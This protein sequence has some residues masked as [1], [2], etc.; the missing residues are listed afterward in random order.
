MR[1]TLMTIGLFALAGTAIGASAVVGQAGDPDHE[2][3]DQGR[4]GDRESERYC[5][6]REFTLPA[7]G[8][9]ISVDGGANGGIE[10]EGW[11][12][13][14]IRLTVK[15]QGWTR[16]GDPAEIVSDVEIQTDRG[17]RAEGPRMGRREGWS[18]SYRMM[19]PA[20]SDLSLETVNGGISVAE[21][22]G[23][24]GFRAVNGGIN[25]TGVGGTVSGRTTN[26]GISV[27]LSGSQWD[28]SGLDVETTNGGVTL[29]VPDDFRADLETGT[30]NGGLEIDFPVTIQGRI[31]RRRISTELN[32]GGPRVRA[33]T[34]NGGV[35]VR[36]N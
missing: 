8:R 12:R 28:G 22:R 29:W 27:E 30:V 20:G 23:D 14:E 17:I 9:V 6:V 4:R 32:G 31:N 16:D 7:D 25:L 2:W 33:V 35:R 1:R 3:C 34:T 19:V 21:V 10:V 15:V 5:E 13:S 36:R 18:A 11:D 24:I 26:G